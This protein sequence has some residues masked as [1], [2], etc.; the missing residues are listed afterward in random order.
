MIK[1]LLKK[2]AARIFKKELNGLYTISAAYQQAIEAKNSSWRQSDLSCHGIV[3][4]K[5]RAMQ[6]HALLSS[7][8]ST[9]K[10][11]APLTILYTTSSERHEHSYKELRLLFANRA[12]TF[13]KERS[14]KKDVE[15]IVTNVNVQTIFFMTDDGLFIDSFDMDEIAGFNPLKIVPTLIKGLDLTYCYIQN[16]QQDL[17]EFIQP[18]QLH[19]SANMK[20][21]EWGNAIPGSD[22]AYPLSL[23]TT[24]YNRSEL[25]LLL[26]QIQYKGPNSLESS[27]HNNYHSVFLKRKGICYSKA[28]YVN[29]VCNVVNS[30]HD[31]RNTGLHSVESL[32]EKWEAG[33]KINIEEFA[34]LSCV[35][36]ETKL[37]S[38]LKRN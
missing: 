29:I 15:Q 19:L 27:L 34:G 24:F 13:Y 12:V 31:N 28:K 11:P 3:F 9:V 6:L 21:W 14:F 8:F 22:W 35:E 7:Y 20:C 26:Q 10:K 30:E 23:D 16:K 36:A 5:D 2:I 4:S 25:V 38:F 18:D 32:L 33:Y 37:F 17:P 1:A